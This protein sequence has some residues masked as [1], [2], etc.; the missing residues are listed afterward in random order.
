M[1]GRCNDRY[2]MNNLVR[3]INNISKM[4]FNFC[5][6][7]ISDLEKLYKV[8]DVY[9]DLFKS[10]S[11]G[12][13]YSDDV[14][15]SMKAVYESGMIDME[16]FVYLTY[17]FIGRALYNELTSDYSF[18]SLEDKIN[19]TIDAYANLNS[20][21]EEGLSEDSNWRQKEIVDMMKE[22]SFQW[23]TIVNIN[24]SNLIESLIGQY[25]GRHI[26]GLNEEH[27][28]KIR[29]H[30]LLT[31]SKLIPA[32]KSINENLS[33]PAKIDSDDITNKLFMRDFNKTIYGHYW[34]ECAQNSTPHE[35]DLVYIDAKILTLNDHEKMM[36][37][38]SL[39]NLDVSE[40]KMNQCVKDRIL[41]LI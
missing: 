40:Y 7:D 11:T 17:R 6:E 18:P 20:I 16:D 10:A 30:T 36:V 2:G 19:F 28:D 35:K 39:L 24:S 26:F 27:H 8:C 29:W 5:K 23:L 9:Y 14:Y 1:L 38:D 32:S 34:I 22:E 3:H 13:Y 41:N 12:M 33:K 15:R 25:Y 31:H 4:D 37:K 21:I